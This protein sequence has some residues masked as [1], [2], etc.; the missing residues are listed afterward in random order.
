[1][2]EG[3]K[4]GITGQKPAHGGED[5]DRLPRHTTPT[6]E[7][8]LLISG[9]A[10]FA[11]LQLPGWLDDKL[12][13][14]TPRFDAEWASALRM[15]YIYLKCAALILAFSF[16]LHLL[17]RAQWIALVG[18]HSVYPDGVRWEKL[19]MGPLYRAANQRQS[20][21]T[22]EAIERADNR[23]TIVFA[24]GVMLATFM[25]VLG[26]AAGLFFA[27]SISIMAALGLDFDPLWVFTAAAMLLLMPMLILRIVDRRFG[28]RLNG[29]GRWQRLLTSMINL[30]TRIRP[31]RG[32]QVMML[33][34]SHGNERHV[35]ILVFLVFFMAAFAVALGIAGV[36]NP[37]LVGNYALFPDI[38]AHSGQAISASHYDDQRDP[39]HDPAV[40]YVQGA[41]IS[42]P[43]LQLVVP[44]QP[45]RDTPALRDKCAGALALSDDDARA[46]A[47]LECL[48][49]LHAASLDGEP[50]SNLRY[51][52]G[53]DP[54]TNRPALV[55]MIDVRD[56]AAGRHLL[57]VS[58]PPRRDREHHDKDDDNITVIPFWR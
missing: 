37:E 28:H 42:G 35:N 49:Q 39:A 32:S 1:M 15:L 40:P 44:Y 4:R 43:Y 33:M 22:D 41:V 24:F 30:H 46:A 47:T 16:A 20:R 54:R 7:V 5:S 6:W 58:N 45:S 34:A 56:L 26:I 14:L 21:P 19:R 10:V 52:S 2:S 27:I 18:M 38:S 12:F 25:L 9:V 55:A 17:L 13:M 11:M 48:A 8:E 3:E 31:D 51:D 53:S 50:L 29:T 36:K 57:R 23:A